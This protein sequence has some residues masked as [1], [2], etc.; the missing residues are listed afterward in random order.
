M[1]SLYYSAQ[2]RFRQSLTL[3]QPVPK[4]YHQPLSKQVTRI[5]IQLPR[6]PG[7]VLQ[8][9]TE[10][11]KR[12]TA[13]QHLSVMPAPQIFPEEVSHYAIGYYTTDWYLGTCEPLHPLYTR[14]CPRT[15]GVTRR[16]FSPITPHAKGISLPMS[17]IAVSNASIFALVGVTW[18]STTRCD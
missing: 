3:I 7:D 2:F 18:S 17:N 10:C 15:G 9:L 12:T 6:L 4:R 11:M 5:F 13:S 8:M 14:R 16:V 1:R